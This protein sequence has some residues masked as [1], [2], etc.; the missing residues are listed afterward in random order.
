MK[1]V[2][3]QFGDGRIEIKV[4]DSALVARTPNAGQVSDPAAETL[5]GLAEPIGAPPLRELARG[6]SNA[7]VVVSDNT[8]PVPYSG[9]GGI[10]KPILDTLRL[11]GVGH[12]KIIVGCGNHRPMTEPE[13]RRMLGDEAFGDGI[14][15]INHASSDESMLRDI[16]STAR[17]EHVTI[18][19][20][21]LDAELKI[22]T[23]LVE[24]HCMAGYSGGRKAICPG[25]AGRSVAWGFHSARIL[26]EGAA[27]TLVL[28]ENPLHQEALQVARMAGADFTVN[29]TVDGA[30]QLT[31]IFCGELELAHRAAVEFLNTY[32]TIPLTKEYDVVITQVGEVGINHYQCVKGV[33]EASR[34][35]KPSGTIIAV[36][37]LTDVD[38]IGGTNYKEMIRLLAALGPDGYRRKLLSDDWELVPDQWGAQVWGR[39]FEKIGD[40]RRLH[41]CAPQLAGCPEDQIPEVN[42]A[43]QN[44]REPGESDPAYAQRIL[45]QTIDN[46]VAQAPQADI[47]ILPDGP[48]AIPVVQRA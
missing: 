36:G 21:Y 9:P 29:V 19:R 8:R 44:K 16:G 17:T 37:D 35:I 4:P 40:P 27:T 3:L 15:I 38:P 28:D 48:Y 11:E 6:C 10:L 41:L 34:S 14:E 39:V 46:V 13:L 2:P 22:L 5:R 31:G 25:I 23:G 33:L 30:K 24:P 18:N 20:H 12:I 32:V 47:L 45:Q 26:T 42:V 1:R 43:A 7:A